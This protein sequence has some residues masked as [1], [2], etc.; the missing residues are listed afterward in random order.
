MNALS[1]E[2]LIRAVFKCG[3]TMRYGADA[4]LYRGLERATTPVLNRSVD[5][6]QLG[7]KVGEISTYLFEALKEVI[8]Q[9]EENKDF[10]KKIEKCKDYLYEPTFEKI[11][12]CIEETLSA[13]K[14]IG[15][16]AG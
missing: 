4:D 12:M 15:L 6:Y 1:Y 14:E 16:R 9:N 7:L 8:A 13:F 10:V 5:Q 11:E 2:Y 3:R